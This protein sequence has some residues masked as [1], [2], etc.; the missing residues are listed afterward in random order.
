MSCPFSLA[1]PRSAARLSRCILILPWLL[2]T[3]QAA[4]GDLALRK[5][6]SDPT[7]MPGAAVEFAIRVE[8]LGPG[9]SASVSVVDPLPAGLSLPDGTAPVT[10]A[11]EYDIGTGEWSVGE[12]AEGASAE[13]RLPAL[14]VADPLPPCIVNRAAVAATTADPVAANDTAAAAL[15]RPDVERCVDLTVELVREVDFFPCDTEVVQ[16]FVRLTNRGTDTAREVRV[17]LEDSAAPP[18]GLA[19]RDAFCQSGSECT[20]ASLPAGRTMLLDLRS[21]TGIRNREPQEFTAAVAAGSTDPDFEPGQES[22]SL[23][24]VKAPYGNCP[25]FVDEDTL[26]DTGGDGMCFIATAAFGSSMHPKVREL[27]RFRDRVLLTSPRG[28][29]L[30]GLYYRASPPLAAYIAERPRMRAVVRGMLAPV[31]WSIV[32]PA[33]AAAAWGLALAAGLGLALRRSA[34]GGRRD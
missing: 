8:N 16:L 31:I 13:M 25:E 17:T 26:F 11:G 21:Q 1:A 9:P 2:L 20:V 3:A 14:V 23:S 10:S 24:Y 32:H 6:V 12:L 19:F 33:A 22:A 29:A 7:L 18:P 15:R 28:R 30:V 5:S 27:R 4:A 34:P